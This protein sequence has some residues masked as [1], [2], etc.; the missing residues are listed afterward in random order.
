VI[1]DVH[2]H[3]LP[4]NFGDFMGDRFWPRV[5]APVK[6]GLARH[7]FSVLQDYEA[8]TETFVYIES[9]GLPQADVDK[10]LHHNAQQLFGFNH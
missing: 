9:L 1:V 7:L 5:G 10:I 8:Y 2:T 4:K 6:T 3:Y